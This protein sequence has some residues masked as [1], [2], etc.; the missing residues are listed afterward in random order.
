MQLWTLQ[1]T[2][3]LWNPSRSSTNRRL[4]LL[5]HIIWNSALRPDQKRLRTLRMHRTTWIWKLPK[6]R[7]THFPPIMN[8]IM[9]KQVRAHCLA[10]NRR[11]RLS[12]HWTHHLL[13]PRHRK[14]MLILRRNPQGNR[15]KDGL[16]MT[17]PLAPGM[18]GEY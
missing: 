5:L 2:A 10:L 11:Y 7:V 8:L 4:S 13:R 15:L 9:R 17:G 3:E 16:P 6:F 1:R 18:L 12:H 14:L